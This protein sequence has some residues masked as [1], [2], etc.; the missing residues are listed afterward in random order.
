MALKYPQ[1]LDYDLPAFG[2]GGEGEKNDERRRTTFLGELGILTMF[3]IIFTG[4][5]LDAI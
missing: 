3:D 5:A 1:L 2:G 4:I